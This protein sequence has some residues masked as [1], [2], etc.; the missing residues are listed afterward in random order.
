[1]TFAAHRER[2]HEL[3]TEYVHAIDDER[4]EAWPE[5]F[6][7][8]CVYRVTT[9]AALK[10]GYL[11]GIIDCESKGMLIDRINSLRRANIYEP[12]VYRHL[13]GP[14]RVTGVDGARVMA[15]TGF[16]VMRIVEGQGA[17]VF[18]TGVYDDV[19]TY[20][21]EDLLLAERVVVLDSS[22]VDTLLVLPI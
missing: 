19:F 10:R 1:M 20:R 13:L 8:P 17:A 21:G 16:T 7:D 4:Y 18:L 22:C 14:T 9:R 6:T 2:I 12:H 3:L 11:A 15:R 5:F